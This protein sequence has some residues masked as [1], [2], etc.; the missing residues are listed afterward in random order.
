MV[1]PQGRSCFGVP[2]LVDSPADKMIPTIIFLESHPGRSVHHSIADAGEAIL[3]SLRIVSGD[4]FIQE[5]QHAPDL[6]LQF[7]ILASQKLI[8]SL[9]RHT[10]GF[11]QR[12]AFHQRA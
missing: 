11:I 10:G 12:L 7:L 1:F 3:H 9:F 4:P 8:K 2:I 6:L 5:F